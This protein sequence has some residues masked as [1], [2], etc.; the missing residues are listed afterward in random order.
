[1]YLE[2]LPWIL[3]KPKNKSIIKKDWFGLSVSS[4]SQSLH[5]YYRL[6]KCIFSYQ[7]WES[8]VVEWNYKVLNTANAK[9]S[10]IIKKFMVFGSFGWKTEIYSIKNSPN[11]NFFMEEKWN[12]IS[13]KKVYSAN[14]LKSSLQII[15]KNKQFY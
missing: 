10:E 8:V 14:L 3:K 7:T 11:G 9:D 12:H 6:G 5:Y 13:N 2:H 15:L 4:L 1:M